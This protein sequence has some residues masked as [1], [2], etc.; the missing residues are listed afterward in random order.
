MPRQPRG[1]EPAA[2]FHITSR[3][4]DRRSIFADDHD[5]RRFLALLLKTGR[6]DRLL[7]LDYCLM[8]NHFHLAVQALVEPLEVVMRDVLG[9]YARGFNE[10]HDREGHLFERRFRSKRVAT[11]RYLFALARYLAYNPVVAGLSAAPR[12][13]PW[14]GCRELCGDVPPTVTAV[15]QALRYFG[16]SREVGRRAYRNLIA[17][18]S[19]RSVALSH[20]ACAQ[21][22]A[23]LHTAIYAAHD[24]ACTAD[25]IAAAASR[26][27]KS[28]QRLLRERGNKSARH[29]CS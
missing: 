13:W 24:L 23:S 25:E 27:V 6:E 5:R 7:C 22:P 21:D 3:G 28:I 4:V 9:L 18:A 19:E 26:H 1:I 8:G 12:D 11:E 10:R 17:S 20:V 15:D 16:E 29:F 14:S 2:V